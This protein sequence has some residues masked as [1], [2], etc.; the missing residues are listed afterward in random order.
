MAIDNR[1][2]SMEL[3]IQ[4]ILDDEFEATKENIE[5]EVFCDVLNE[6]YKGENKKPY[7]QHIQTV[8]TRLDIWKIIKKN[9]KDIYEF[10]NHLKNLHSTMKNENSYDSVTMSIAIIDAHYNVYV[11][12]RDKD[13]VNDINKDNPNLTEMTVGLITDNEKNIEQKEILNEINKELFLSRN[14][15]IEW[16]EK[17]IVTLKNICKNE[18]LA[19]QLYWIRHEVG[20]FKSTICKKIKEFNINCNNINCSE[21]TIKTPLTPQNYT[22]QWLKEEMNIFVTMLNAKISI[23]DIVKEL[24]RMEDSISRHIDSFEYFVEQDEWYIKIKEPTKNDFDE[25]YVDEV[26]NSLE[27]EKSIYQKNNIDSV[28]DLD[29]DG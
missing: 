15:L 23:L 19:N 24:K 12:H 20:K 8:Y 28:F 27:K 5:K 11:N 29:L 18:K 17:E 22:K 14:E 1:K 4:F 21:Q 9:D 7:R 26:Y 13:F 2:N 25:A 16:T 10:Y 6:V 3:L